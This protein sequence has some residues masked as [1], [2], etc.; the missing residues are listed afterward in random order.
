MADLTVQR[1]MKVMLAEV[2]DKSQQSVAFSGFSVRGLPV[3]SGV[4]LSN[5]LQRLR[6]VQVKSLV[7]HWVGCCHIRSVTSRSSTHRFG[8]SILLLYH[9]S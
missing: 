4:Y 3:V 7:N 8:T 2:T 5:P 1:A 6:T 9:V